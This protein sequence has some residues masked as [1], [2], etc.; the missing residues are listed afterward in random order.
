[1]R[2]SV[3]AAIGISFC[4]GVLNISAARS[5]EAPP[6]SPPPLL[7]PPA[8]VLQTP[9]GSPTR[10]GLAANPNASAPAAPLATVGGKLQLGPN[11]LLSL[12]LQGQPP[13]QTEGPALDLPAQPVNPL[14]SATTATDP[15]A[16]TPQSKIAAPATAALTTA[17]ASGGS[18]SQDQ[19]DKAYSKAQEPPM[20]GSFT[21]DIMVDVP[22]FRG[23]EPK[24]SLM[25]D[26]NISARPTGATAG[27][28]G[29]GWRMQ[30][31]SEIVRTARVR[32]A[33]RFDATDTFMLDGEELVACVAGMVS[34]SCTSGGTH[35]TRVESWRRITQTTAANTWTVTA[36]DGTAYRY[37]SIGTIANTGSPHTDI[38]S[39][40]RWLLQTVTD[41]HGNVVTY[42]WTCTT[43]PYCV[44]AQIVYNGTV[45]TFYYDG[46]PDPRTYGTGRSLATASY[47]L[48]TIGITTGGARVRAYALAYDTSP[49]TSVTRLTSVTPYGKDAGIDANAAVTGTA[50]PT[51]QMGYTNPGG[52]TTV[53]G[54]TLT[55]SALGTV[56]EPKIWGNFRGSG[57]REQLR[58]RCS[59]SSP[60]DGCTYEGVLS[61]V[62][63]D[64][65]ISDK[66]LS[67][68]FG[69][70]GGFTWVGDFDG[71]GKDDIV[72]FTQ[73]Y[74]VLYKI[75]ETSVQEVARIYRPFIWG[76]LDILVSN[77]GAGDFSGIGK[78]ELFLDGE[79]LSFDG[80]ALRLRPAS[81]LYNTNLIITPRLRFGDFNGDGK[82]DIILMPDAY[83]PVLRLLLT[84]GSIFYASGI[85]ADHWV[86]VNTPDSVIGDFNGDGLADV[87]Q[88]GFD[89]SGN[90]G[91][92][93]LFLSSGAGF[94]LVPKL[95]DQA[96]SGHCKIHSPI[97][98]LDHNLTDLLIVGA[99]F[100][101]P[102]ASKV[103]RNKNPN[104]EV[105]SVSFPGGGS[106]VGTG[107]FDGDGDEET[108][109]LVPIGSDPDSGLQ[110]L[111]IHFTSTGPSPDLL[112]SIKS[113]HGGETR[114]TY[115]PSSAWAS[116][117]VPYVLQTVTDVVQ[118]NGLGTVG[119][120]H[121]A[122]SGGFYDHVERRFLGFRNA[123]AMLPCNAGETVCPERYYTFRQ[124]VASAGAIEEI[125]YWTGPR[126]D[127]GTTTPGVMLRKDTETWVVNT[128]I[129][130][131]PYR[132]QNTVSD[133]TIYDGAAKTSRVE[134]TFDAYNNVTSL[135]ERGDID[136]T[137]DDVQTV[138][139][140]VPNTS[141]YIVDHPATEVQNSAAGTQLAS[142]S[143]AYDGLAQGAAPVRGDPTSL[144]RWLDLPAG[145][146]APT[147]TMTYDITTG[148]KLTEIDETGC[149]TEWLYDATY[150]LFPIETRNPLYFG[151]L[152]KAADT[153]Q[154]TT[155]VYDP[156][157]QKPTETRDIDTLATTYTYEP[158]CRPFQVIKPGGQWSYTYYADATAAVPRWDV[159]YVTTAL[160][161]YTNFPN[162]N[163]YD[164]FGRIYG[165][166]QSAPPS[167]AA[168]N[169]TTSYTYTLYHPRGTVVNE[170]L[171]LYADSGATAQWTY[172][173]YDA[174]NRKTSTTHPDG[175]VMTMS[176]GSGGTLSDG[177]LV[178][179]S[180]RIR[181]ELGRDTVTS[182]D[183][184]GHILEIARYLGTG[185]V[186]GTPNRMR[187][188]HDPLD[189]LIEVTDEPGNRW[190]A[191]YDSLGRRLSV[192][193]PVH[194]TWTFTYDAAGRLTRQVDANAAR[195]DFV[196]DGLGRMTKRE[197]RTSA[198]TL[199][200]THTST[201]D[202]TRIVNTVQYRNGGKLTSTSSH[203]GATTV[204]ADATR[205]Y[206]YDAN[207]KKILD[208]WT[209]KGAAYSI[210]SSHDAGGY[211]YAKAYSDGDTVGSQ[212]SQ[213]LYDEAGRLK[214][215]PGHI[216][217]LKYNARGQVI[218]ADYA[219]GVVTTNT[220]NDQRGWLMRVETR[221]G[222]TALQDFTFTRD[223]TGRITQVVSATDAIDS[224]T[225]TYDTLDRLLSATNAA[226]AVNNQTFTYDAAHNMASNSLVGTY[227]Y[228]VQG[229]GVLRPHAVTAAGA[230]TYTYDA[231]GNM[232]AKKQGTTTLYALTWN[233]ENKLARAT[234][235]AVQ[236]NY[237]YDA[238]HSRVLK[239]Q[240]TNTT[241]YLGGEV[242]ITPTGTWTKYIHD[243][244]KRVGNGA[245]AA[246]FFHHRDHLKTI[247]VIT[248]GVGVAGNRTTFRPYGA[249][250]R[251][252]GTHVET[253]GFIGERHDAETGFLYLN[254]RYYDPALARF[255]S[256]DWWDPNQP[257]VGTNRYTYSDNDPIN[258][259]D[260][261][262]HQTTN[263]GVGHNSSPNASTPSGAAAPAQAASDRAAARA[264]AVSLDAHISMNEAR[265][266][267]NESH[268][269]ASRAEINGA[270]AATK[271]N[272]VPY[273]HVREVSERVRSLN[274]T[275]D[276]LNKELANP[277]LTKEARAPVHDA[278]SRASRM[279][280]EVEKAVPGISAHSRG[281]TGKAGQQP[282][283]RGAPIGPMPSGRFP[284]NSP[285]S[286]STSRPRAD[287]EEM[288]PTRSPKAEAEVDNSKSNS[289]SG[290]RD[291]SEQDRS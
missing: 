269:A 38:T 80:V 145:S 52:A 250:A 194:G 132:A 226:G 22:K 103:I 61:T 247:R 246:K 212:V 280:D 5:A 59:A 205:N 202:E 139:T 262:G 107:D 117:K 85:R 249:K 105:T 242:E 67:S 218:R 174:L 276:K 236:H 168:L 20:N 87:A 266:V 188:R 30:G 24:L 66:I 99:G 200:H 219:N 18:S 46:R 170:M 40:Y 35:T 27:T 237:I 222:A 141:L 100:C 159:T 62:N 110:A 11:G 1:M 206:D 146:A 260:A 15:K 125:Q 187:M 119:T 149:K 193:D 207:G 287:N 93:R 70:I 43:L 244:V 130:T 201:Y 239:V 151:C 44:I 155:A 162:F 204:T 143:I 51:T 220:Y 96:L 31:I 9:S 197:H 48:K 152:G 240:G 278:L 229:L 232:T 133:R 165:R 68:S 49:T 268:Y 112:S 54:P 186:G 34:P 122:Y 57:K 223:G 160:G 254:A 97:R 76:D 136:Q 286:P 65:T 78:S 224:W 290:S 55:A 183:G 156:V 128:N 258:N 115:T 259:A 6:I 215:I 213:W 208:R 177:R 134:R 230:H 14:Q 19:A 135:W 94:E 147:R 10:P 77:Y 41:T 140:F 126:P 36:R 241:R 104:F 39:N 256:P 272:G 12:P 47:R 72:E 198:G 121:F 98:S 32:G 102:D 113:P 243:D 118:D 50:L 171:P 253:K 148:N 285:W 69:S 263:G 58:F 164:G 53:T 284:S 288:T 56:F 106:W 153:R 238:K 199:T 95:L 179:E 84:D 138:K 274:T 23:L 192:A 264:S 277:N 120:T 252:L 161:A 88:G 83:D 114:V 196:Y 16:A 181:D 267:L 163:Y 167:T 209:L 182:K 3:V 60:P 231:A 111:Q 90:F 173:T 251:V 91:L 86:G 64:A 255:I 235:G 265:S 131:L 75:T 169:Y 178:F 109:W 291:Q 191:T 82:T 282:S 8:T 127:T 92:V 29:I 63:S 180:V 166:L 175:A 225:Y 21:H 157:C 144:A 2:R 216:T 234:L 245:A 124:D 233:A 154:K 89:A 261:S 279:K 211:L 17:A 176:Y 214:S 150:K 203:P 137:A 184:R 79:I 221:L 172:H 271:P 101:G 7:A 71:D 270:I 74:Y 283:T 227:T 81:N 42:S 289:Q 45:I 129:A 37:I 190:T 189:R 4:V 28:L 281:L 195:S 158:F 217:S 108:L 26:S 142:K 248:D 257:G 73:L 123:R 185:Q 228:P 33:P 273:D 13:K 275:I 25:Y 210:T 116:N